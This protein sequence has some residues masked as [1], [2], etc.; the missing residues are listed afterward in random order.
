[1]PGSLYM[2]KQSPNKTTFDVG[3]GMSD[4]GGFAEPHCFLRDVANSGIERWGARFRARLR[5]ARMGGRRL[6]QFARAG[7]I[8]P[9]WLR[10]R[11]WPKA[12]ALRGTLP[13]AR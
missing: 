10:M 1:M 9:R 2:V 5:I 11:M 3:F 6:V 4:A 8:E 13:V 12:R 7:A